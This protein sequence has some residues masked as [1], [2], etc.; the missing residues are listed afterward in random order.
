MQIREVP[1]AAD[2][3]AKLKPREAGSRRA[4]RVERAVSDRITAAGAE[5]FAAAVGRLVR[6][7][8][9]KRGMTRRQLAQDSGASE[10]YLA[11]IE[12]GQGNPSVIML[13]SIAEALDVPMFELLP[14]S[15]ARTAELDRILD[16]LL[17]VP[18]SELSSLAELIET[19]AAPGRLR[20]PRAADRAGRLA[21]RRQVD[22]WTDVGRRTRRALHRTRPHGRAGLRRTGS[23]PDRDGRARHLPTLRARLPR[24]R[25]RR[26]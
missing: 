4:T 12:G 1:L 13:K 5:D 26:A 16:L 7:A 3:K 2:P 15:G 24:T 25:R 23:R 18:P 19:R 6:L 22:A 9:A 21:R 20:R 14:R 10:R 17:R 11:Q 8:R